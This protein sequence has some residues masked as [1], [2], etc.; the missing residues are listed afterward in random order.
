MQYVAFNLGDEVLCMSKPRAAV[1]LQTPQD[2]FEMRLDRVIPLQHNPCSVPSWRLL[3]ECCSRGPGW[4]AR[5]VM[6][7][8]ELLNAETDLRANCAGQKRCC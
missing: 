2:I 6:S 5:G 8:H 7:A 3:I 4:E 1:A